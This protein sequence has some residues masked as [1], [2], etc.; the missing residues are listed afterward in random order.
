MGKVIHFA[1]LFLGHLGL[2]NWWFSFA[3]IFQWHCFTP[4]GV[5]NTFL[6]GHNT[7]L[8]QYVFV[9]S[10][11]LPHHYSETFMRTK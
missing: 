7:F 2:L 10:S 3:L 11:S 9:G 4:W 6:S 8:S 1:C 5:N